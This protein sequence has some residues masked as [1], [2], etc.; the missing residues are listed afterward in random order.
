MAELKVYGS[1]G[2]FKAAL[3]E[4]IRARAKS[5][6]V[7]TDRARSVALMERFLAR[8]VAVFPGTTVLKGG[9]ALELRLERARSTKDI[10]LRLLG[11][12]AAADALMH[13]AA[14]HPVDPD[15]YLTFS[16][17]VDP[18]HPAIHGK[19]AVYEG[20]RYR[21]TAFLASV[22]FG[23]PFGV[24]VSFADAL[25]GEPVELIGGDAFA[26]IGVPPLK[27]R[28][29]PAGSHI[30]E[31][32]HAYTLPRDSGN[33][34]TRVKDLP[35]IALLAGI[36]GMEAAELLAAIHAT[37]AFRNTHDVPGK[38]P[39][40]PVSWSARYAQMAAEDGLVWRALPELLGAVRA[41][42]DPVLAG[43][44]GVWDAAAQ[45]WRVSM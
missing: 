20:V 26:F 4:R 34:N 38:L 17:V 24:D 37:F 5:E 33:E 35:D 11:E 6:G 18:E 42:I 43:E 40:P 23:P 22:Q 45:T 3:A 29:Y 25:H 41:F 30:A 7:P 2:A 28:A 1:P 36:D 9:L 16:A 12:P 21:V 14:A 13:R 27:I 31:K 39:E 10:D 8:V 32:L 19:S 44:T 15:D